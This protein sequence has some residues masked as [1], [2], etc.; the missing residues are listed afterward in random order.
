LDDLAVPSLDEDGEGTGEEA[1][2]RA[3]LLMEEVAST[4]VVG[5]LSQDLGYC[6]Q[7]SASGF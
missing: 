3:R 2:D 5:D 6:V 1:L 4:A 7:E